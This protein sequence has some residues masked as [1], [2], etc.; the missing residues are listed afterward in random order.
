[1]SGI[2]DK[3]RMYDW[4]GTPVVVWEWPDLPQAYKGGG[5]WDIL[6]DGLWK[7]WHEA[8][9]IKQ[10]QFEKLVKDF[11]AHTGQSQPS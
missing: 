8:S 11:D 2:T 5:K 1:M 7:I 4:D 9:R 10:D 3:S 6:S